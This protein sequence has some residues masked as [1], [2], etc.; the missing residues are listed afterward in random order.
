[1]RRSKRKL[2]TKSEHF[3]RQ[4]KLVVPDI[5]S[6]YR[7]DLPDK[8]FEDVQLPENLLHHC[9]RQM[10]PHI[11]YK[12]IPSSSSDIEDMSFACGQRWDILL[13]LLLQL[14]YVFK[15]KESIRLRYD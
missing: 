5:V 8:W 6:D 11:W 7:L 1:M 9:V 13:P 2:E 12:I 3:T 14:K 10:L 15:Y 4:T